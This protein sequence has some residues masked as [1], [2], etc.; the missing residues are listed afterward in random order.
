MKELH[1][2]H[3]KA[4]TWRDTC[5]YELYIYG[6]DETPPATTSGPAQDLFKSVIGNGAITGKRPEAMWEASAREMKAGTKRK[7]AERQGKRESYQIW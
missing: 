5:A 7:E 1:G 4:K 3:R 2:S 6:D